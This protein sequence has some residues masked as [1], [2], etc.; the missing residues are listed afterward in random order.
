MTS[1]RRRLLHV[2]LALLLRPAIA[3]QALT[4]FANFSIYSLV[5]PFDSVFVCNSSC[6]AEQRKALQLFY[7]ETGGDSW[8]VRSEWTAD[9][10]PGPLDTDVHC[11]WFGISCCSANNTV[12]GNGNTCNTPGGVASITLPNN[13]LEGTLSEDFIA[14]VEQTMTIIDLHGMLHIPLL[15]QKCFYCFFV[16]P[17]AATTIMVHPHITSCTRAGT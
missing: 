16:N 17:A 10:A 12:Q 1:L 11:N 9:D 13:N 4:P 8:T 5:P 6:Q 7:N 2:A 3:L 14:A 15:H